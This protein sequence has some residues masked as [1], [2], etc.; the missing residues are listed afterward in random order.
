MFGF[1]SPGSMGPKIQAAIDF[2]QK[3]VAAGRPDAWAAIGDLRDAALLVSNEEGTIIRDDDKLKDG[4]IW[5]PR[6]ETGTEQVRMKE[7][8]EPH[9]SG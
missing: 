1:Y 5:R 4:V 2:V 7:S 3:S 8:K 9:K 6:K